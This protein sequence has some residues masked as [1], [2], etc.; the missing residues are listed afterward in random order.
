[1]IAIE[2]LEPMH[3]EKVAGWL[4][5]KSINRW[6]T[7]EWRNRE[8]DPKLLAIAVRNKKN[9]LFL[10]RCDGE[11]CGLVGLADIDLADRTA[12]AWYL[13]GE[14]RHARCGVTSSALQQMIRI[15]F[16]EMNLA[17]I[18][19]WIMEGNTPSRRVLEKC[20]FKEAGRLRQAAS[21]EGIQVSRVFF[22]VTP[23]DV[24]A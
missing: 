9:R 24:A 1:M 15:A 16:G 2:D 21:S 20:G 10:V 5:Q 19:A 22:D 11:P 12:M 23:A 13:L 7:T 4:S 6:L 18:Y 14:A 3:F 17:S 8:I